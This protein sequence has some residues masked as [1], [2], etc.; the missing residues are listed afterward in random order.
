MG[1]DLC[2]AFA[3]YSYSYD[4]KIKYD[5]NFTYNNSSLSNCNDLSTDGSEND[6]N[7]ISNTK[8]FL[9]DKNSLLNDLKG[10]LEEIEKN[11]KNKIELNS[12]DGGYNID[13]DNDSAGSD[14]EPSI[15]NFENELLS[16]LM[17]VFAKKKS[18]TF[19]LITI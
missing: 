16:K 12:S 13:S 18:N 2:R 8:I 4:T 7:K 15:D 5:L 19:K 1:R 11:K 9:I 14:S 10:E 17:P 6:N 3:S